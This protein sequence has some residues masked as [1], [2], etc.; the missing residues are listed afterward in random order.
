MDGC[1]TL[2]I[3]VVVTEQYPKGLGPTIA[4]LAERTTGPA[5]EKDTFSCAREST[6]RSAIEDLGRNQ[7]VV[8]GIEAHVCVMQTA[9]DLLAAGYEVHVPHDG[10]NSRRTADRDWALHRMAAAGAIITSTESV[11]FELLERCGTD[12]FKRVAA[13]IKEI[14]L[15]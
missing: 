2:A 5:I 7:V 9:A 12:D 4:E 1:A 8:T 15:E 6:A 13:L 11:L 10:V 14:P 3:P